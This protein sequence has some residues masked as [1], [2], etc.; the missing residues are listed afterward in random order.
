MQDFSLDLQLKIN[1]QVMCLSGW[2]SQLVDDV[3][4]KEVGE[5]LTHSYPGMYLIHFAYSVFVC[6]GRRCV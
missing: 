6:W 2:V 5:A 1:V 3:R 4:C